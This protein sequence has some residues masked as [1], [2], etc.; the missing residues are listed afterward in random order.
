MFIA[1]RFAFLEYADVD[2]AQ[3]A[4]DKYNGMEINGNK[5]NIEFN[6]GCKY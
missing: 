1:F 6:P 3:E 2:T 4:L 5:I